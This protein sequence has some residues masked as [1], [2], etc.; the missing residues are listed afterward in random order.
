MGAGGRPPPSAARSGP[1]PAVQ[2]ADYGSEPGRIR[3]VLKVSRPTVQA[4]IT[5]VEAEPWA[6]LLDTPRGPQEPPR[7]SWL[8]R[9]GPVVHRPQAPL[10]AGAFRIWRRWAPP[11]SS[12]RTGGCL[13][14]RTRLVD[15]AIPHGPQRG[16]PTPS[17]PHPD[18][19]RARHQEWCID[20][21]PM[22]IA[23][24]GVQ[25]G[26]L[27]RREGDARPMRARAPTEVPWGALRGLATACRQDGGPAYVVSDRGGA[28]PAHAC[29][30]V[31]TR[32]PS[33]HE[34]L[35]S[36]LGAH[37]RHGRDTPVL[38]QRRRDDDQGTWAR[39]PAALA[40]RQQAFLQTSNTTAPHGLM[41]ARDSRR[42]RS[43]AWGRP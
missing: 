17:G 28:S 31:W 11:E 19:A 15:D 30:A 42:S 7:Q 20:G 6:G 14:A 12:G 37:A 5:R 1:P 23:W 26:R 13:R 3:R 32:R 16:G 43:R 24:A 39:P 29:E 27:V 4:W 9:L 21:R 38:M 33:R 18:N 10:D 40:A 35:V 36:T 2:H 25:W 8:P 34:P 41:Q 22:D